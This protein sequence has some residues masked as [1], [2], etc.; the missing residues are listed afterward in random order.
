MTALSIVQSAATV[1]G[2]SVPTALFAQ[3][4]DTSIQVQNALKEAV[5][6]VAYDSNHDWVRLTS[7]ATITGN[8]VA[9]TF[10]FPTD[11]RRMLKKARLW[12]SSSPYAPYTHYPDPD[13]WL[14]IIAQNFAP[15]VGAWTIIGSQINLI[16]NGKN[17]LPNGVTV[18]YMYMTNTPVLSAASAAQ[19]NFLADTDTF[20]LG[21]RML[22]LGFIYRW[23]QD[24][25]QDYGEAMEDYQASL[26]EHVGKDKG[27][28]IIAVGQQRVPNGGNVD[29]AFP[30][31]VS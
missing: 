17:P 14:G 21:E 7:T 4:D 23:K 30:Y 10:N 6:M 27:S 8:G 12:P 11:Y 15:V 9:T 1:I 22:R 24:R 2:I 26:S 29:I 25:G 13:A 28:K 3:T 5:D 19:T 20:P 31:T 16:A 18:K